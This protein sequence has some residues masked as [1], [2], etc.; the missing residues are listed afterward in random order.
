MAER[1]HVLVLN[2]I[3]ANGLS[4]LPAETYR[5][6]KD[7]ADPAAILVRSADMDAAADAVIGGVWVPQEV[8][9]AELPARFGYHLSPQQRV[10][11]QP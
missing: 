1:L 7:V 8:A 2:Q 3:S 4:R 9:F 6:G 11:V 5:V 10:R